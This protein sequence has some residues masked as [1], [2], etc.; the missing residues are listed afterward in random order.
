MVFQ[1]ATAARKLRRCRQR[2]GQF[3]YDSACRIAVVV[4]EGSFGARAQLF[5]RSQSKKPGYLLGANNQQR[6]GGERGKHG[7]ER[8]EPGRALVEIFDQRGGRE[9]RA[10]R[11][12]TAESGPEYGAPAKASLRRKRRGDGDRQIEVLGLRKDAH[13]STRDANVIFVGRQDD[14]RI[15]EAECRGSARHARRSPSRNC[16]ARS[17]RMWGRVGVPARPGSPGGGRKRRKR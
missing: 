1:F 6:K 7:P 5:D 12:Q 2:G 15:V 16:S 3:A 4:A 10:E 17:R 13:R 9:T 11:H 14:M 8:A